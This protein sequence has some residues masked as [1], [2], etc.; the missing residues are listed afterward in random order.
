MTNENHS[1]QVDQALQ[2]FRDQS[3]PEG[4]PVDVER[5]TL[6]QMQSLNRAAELPRLATERHG[7]R[8]SRPQAAVAAGVLLAAIAAWASL[9]NVFGTLAFADIQEQIARIRTARYVDTRLVTLEAGDLKLLRAA[10]SDQADPAESKQTL[11]LG[12]A[13]QP[14]IVSIRGAH[15][16][17]TEILDAEG[18]IESIH[19]SDL[20][21]G[22][23]VILLPRQKKMMD[24]SSQ[25]TIELE[26]GKTSEAPITPTPAVDLLANIREIPPEATTRLPERNIGGKQVVGFFSRQSKPTAGGTVTWERTYWVDPET[27]LPVRIEVSH[28]GTDS[29]IAGSEWVLSGFVFDEDIPESE[30]NTEL[31]AGYA[32][33]TS[34]IMGIKVD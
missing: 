9:V 27:R 12:N 30:F 28:Y 33:E 19:I 34:K 10:L 29:R 11:H 4:P 22:T 3:V 17:R 16:Q 32:R 31:P 8:F 25:V 7:R 23:S 24:F 2:S 6:Q 1:N 5:E 18:N 21:E 13:H 20:K 26:S 15:L 14:R